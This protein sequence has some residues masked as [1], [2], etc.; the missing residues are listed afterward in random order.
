MTRPELAF[1][2]SVF[3]HTID[4]ES[5]LQ[6]G[7]NNP[8]EVCMLKAVSSRRRN[9]LGAWVLHVALDCQFL[10]FIPFSLFSLARLLARFGVRRSQDLVFVQCVVSYVCVEPAGGCLPPVAPYHCL[11]CCPADI[12]SHPAIFT[13]ER[14]DTFC[15]AS[16]LRLG[17]PAVALT[18]S[19]PSL[20]TLRHHDGRSC[21][22]PI[23]GLVENGRVDMLGRLVLATPLT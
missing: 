18:A 20:S 12:L 5:V 22:A 1:T 2:F 21:M 8:A 3:E 17:C 11:H 15:T 13:P 9:P 7:N 14:R 16:F 10:H 6:E 19:W 4:F 23:D